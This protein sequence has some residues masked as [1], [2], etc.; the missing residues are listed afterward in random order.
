MFKFFIF[1]CWKTVY[2]LKIMFEANKTCLQN[3]YNWRLPFAAYDRNL[4]LKI[5][6]PIL[7]S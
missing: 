2:F 5:H 4:L 1:K 3:R 7:D 6:N